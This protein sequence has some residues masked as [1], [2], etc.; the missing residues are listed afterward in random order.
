MVQ[1]KP[2][3]STGAIAGIAVGGGLAVLAVGGL[4]A[5]L[6]LRRKRTHS[7]RS[8]PEGD[9]DTGKSYPLA[10][11][12]LHPHTRTSLSDVGFTQSRLNPTRLVSIVGPRSL[13]PT[14]SG[15]LDLC[16]RRLPLGPS[17]A[18]LEVISRSGRWAVKTHLSAPLSTSTHRTPLLWCLSEVNVSCESRKSVLRSSRGKET[19]R[20]PS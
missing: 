5:L 7:Q 13:R 10:H 2:S 4:S 8:A 11:V 9:N 12:A 19:L 3:L 18:H 15:G 14:C 20:L 17:S 16:P 6:L 1:T